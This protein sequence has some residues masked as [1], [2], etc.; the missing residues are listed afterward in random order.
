MQPTDV[1]MNIK[2]QKS[3]KEEIRK[4]IKLIKVCKAGGPYGIS[5]EANKLF[6]TDWREKDIW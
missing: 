6:S 2:C 1:E 3:L 4:V 5:A